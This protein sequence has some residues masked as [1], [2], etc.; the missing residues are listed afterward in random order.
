MDDEETTSRDDFERLV[1]RERAD[2]RGRRQRRA[3]ARLRLHA[4]IYLAV[5]A[6]LVAGWAVSAS[7]W[8]ATSLWFLPTT[9]GWGVALASH[10]LA[11]RRPRQ[12]TAEP[13]P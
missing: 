9:V 10:A 3:Q 2:R 4:W 5:N 12:Q 11:V 1:A 13:A 7:V 8:D 6:A